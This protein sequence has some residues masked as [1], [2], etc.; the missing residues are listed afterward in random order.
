METPKK[1]KSHKGGTMVKTEP[2]NMH[3][4]EVDPMAREF[5]QR[6]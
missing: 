3:L 2:A 6:V 5:F 4:F 1:K